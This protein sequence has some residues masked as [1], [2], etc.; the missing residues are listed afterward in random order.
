[1]ALYSYIA[2]DPRG[3]R[4][5]GELEASDPDAVVSQLTARGLRAESV[6][7]SAAERAHYQ[8]RASGGLQSGVVREIS[9]HVSEIV[10]AGLPLESG[11]AAVVEELPRGRL[12]RELRAIVADLE[13][14]S[15]LEEVLAGRRAPAYLSALVRAGR[16]SGR[17]GEILESF[18]SSTRI[19]FDLRQ[20]LWMALVYP[21]ALLLVV[22]LIL[23]VL[24]LAVI[25]EFSRIFEGFEIKLPWLTQALIAI[26]KALSQ[27]AWL[28]LLVLCGAVVGICVLIRIALGAV[29]TRR[30]ICKV[31]VIGPLIRWTALARFSPL[32]SL[33]IESRMPLEEA[34]VLAGDATGDVLIRAECRTLA[35]RLR[36]GESLESSA[37]QGGALPASFVRAMSWDK[38]RGALPEVLQSMADMYAGRA[39]ALAVL[40][41]S[42]L[43]IAIVL[44]VG[45][46][47]S[48]V[49]VALFWPLIEL[50]N[51][52][53]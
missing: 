12:K 28:P 45:V 10:S 17:T 36:S 27:H 18:V 41:A 31:P 7:L 44:F 22:P 29:E 26:S 47:S 19:I 6:R 11:L 37:G 40:L 43:P 20:T 4:L 52:L 32:L 5:S 48:V 1:M 14:G 23:G 39:R 49:I 38:Q 16:R 21:L 2:I 33:L 3:E 25:P 15:E 9:E 8:S 46:V 13:R 51:K 34:L 30:I 35:E 53:S 42:L 24:Q 50:L